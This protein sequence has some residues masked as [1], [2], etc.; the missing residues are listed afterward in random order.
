MQL[1][2][3][4]RCSLVSTAASH[5]RRRGALPSLRAEGRGGGRHGLTQPACH[6]PLL[7]C[8]TSRCEPCHAPLAPPRPGLL[9]QGPCQAAQPVRVGARPAARPAPAPRPPCPDTAPRARYLPQPCH[10]ARVTRAAAT[11]SGTGTAQVRYRPASPVPRGGTGASTSTAGSVTSRVTPSP[12]APRPRRVTR[13]G[14]TTRLRHITRRRGTQECPP[15][16]RLRPRHK[17]CQLVPLTAGY[18]LTK[19]N[20]LTPIR[21]PRSVPIPRS[22]ARPVPKLHLN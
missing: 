7:P 15:R 8:P 12:P 22:H 9:A 17:E 20:S 10:S 21:R 13:F 19:L 14:E 4:T 16:S 18:T 5:W 1:V 2:A 3:G 6:T 11:D